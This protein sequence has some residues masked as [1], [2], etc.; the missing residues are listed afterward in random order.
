M[1][2]VCVTLSVQ[3]FKSVSHRWRTITSV[4]EHNIL[5]KVSEPHSPYQDPLERSWLGEEEAGGRGSQLDGPVC[6]SCWRRGQSPDINNTNSVKTLPT[7]W[8]HNCS[9]HTLQQHNRQRASQLT[10]QQCQLNGTRARD[11]SVV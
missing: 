6:F 11:R 7:A 8:H 2:Y 9:A 3:G 4:L 1:Y 10:P 5:K